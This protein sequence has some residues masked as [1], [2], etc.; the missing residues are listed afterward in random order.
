[1]K[2]KKVNMIIQLDLLDP[3]KINAVII[4]G[5]LRNAERYGFKLPDNFENLRDND[6]FKRNFR[7]IFGN[8]EMRY[9][10]VEVNGDEVKITNKINILQIQ[11]QM[12]QPQDNQQLQ[13]EL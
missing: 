4:K 10:R 12:V 7:L 3:E 9:E 13:A 11:P 8:D 2:N 6:E 1:M 5:G